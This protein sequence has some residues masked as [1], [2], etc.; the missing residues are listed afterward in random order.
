MPSPLSGL[1][2]GAALRVLPV[3]EAH[4]QLAAQGAKGLGLPAERLAGDD[5]LAV[6][7]LRGLGRIRVVE[8]LAERPDDVLVARQPEHHRGLAELDAAVALQLQDLLDLVR[9]QVLGLAD[10]VADGAVVQ[11][12]IGR[13]VGFGALEPQRVE[14]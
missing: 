2:E 12:A 7:L 11:H 5:Q 13:V 14:G 3:E 10:D 9:A 8:L 6:E 1:R 4:H